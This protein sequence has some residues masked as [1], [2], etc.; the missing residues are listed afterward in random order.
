MGLR[1]ALAAMARLRLAET[2]SA[3]VG[4]PARLLLAHKKS[5]LELGQSPC[6]H[7]E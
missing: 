1:L 4:Q 3:F 5:S 7:I 2:P 6:L